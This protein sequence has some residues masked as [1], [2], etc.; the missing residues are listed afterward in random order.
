MISNTEMNLCLETELYVPVQF[1][2][3]KTFLKIEPCK[4]ATEKTENANNGALL[5][6]VKRRFS[7]E[8]PIAL[9]PRSY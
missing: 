7:K 4:P 3:E 5:Q 9:C 2:P 6:A 8:I 1:E